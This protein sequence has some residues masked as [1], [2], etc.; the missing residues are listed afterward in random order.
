MDYREQGKQ[1][2]IAVDETCPYQGLQFFTADTAK[3]YCGRDRLVDD[4][5]Q[6]LDESAFVPV[7][8]ASGSGKSSLVR[9]GLLPV[10]E[11]RG[12]D[13]LEPILPGGGM[14]SPAGK[15]ADLLLKRFDDPDEE[16]EV[17]ALL[18]RGKDCVLTWKAVSWRCWMLWI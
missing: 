9:A 4:L 8:G 14:L 2:R 3:W 16:A 15:V 12:W 5:L 7:I 10:V 17:K 6:K 13:I 1:D 18:D 11:K